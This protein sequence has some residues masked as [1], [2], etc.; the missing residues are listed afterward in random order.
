MDSAPSE[1]ESNLAQSIGNPLDFYN[2]RQTQ[3]HFL[4]HLKSFGMFNEPLI[5]SSITIV[6]QKEIMA[7]VNHPK[8][9]R[10][11]PKDSAF[12]P[13][14]TPEYYASIFEQIIKGVAKSK[15]ELQEFSICFVKEWLKALSFKKTKMQSIM[16]DPDDSFH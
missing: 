2:S 10:R 6:N 15:H 8:F 14:Q 11:D 3:L 1:Q 9:S 13:P 5:K 16:F 7:Q 4:K 12:H